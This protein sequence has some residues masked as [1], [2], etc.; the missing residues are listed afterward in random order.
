MSPLSELADRLRQKFPDAQLDVAEPGMPDWVGFLD[1]AYRGNVLAVQWQ[2]DWHFGI[3]S[4]EGHGYGEKADEVYAT[5]DE[6]AARIIW[7][8]LTGNRTVPPLEVTLRELRAEHKLPQTEL[9]ALLGI[10]QPHGLY[11]WSVTSV[12]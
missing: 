12:A 5:V 1:I 3:S 9:A 4:P 8:L 7:L 11:A 6:A 2:K 10:S